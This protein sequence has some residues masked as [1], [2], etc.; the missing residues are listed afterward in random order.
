MKKND[1]LIS[2]KILTDGYLSQSLSKKK[3]NVKNIRRNSDC[4][5]DA[6]RTTSSFDA[7]EYRKKVKLRLKEKKKNL[8]NWL[9]LPEEKN[10]NFIDLNETEIEGNGDR[11]RGRECRGQGREAK[12]RI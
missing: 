1:L 4:S 3:N 11:D 5:K 10:R 8:G 2:G 7:E 6:S 9:P 12:S